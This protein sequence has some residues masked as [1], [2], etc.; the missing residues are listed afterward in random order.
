MKPGPGQPK[1][2]H[3]QELSGRHLP[4]SSN[5]AMRKSFIIHEAGC[6]V[7]ALSEMCMWSGNQNM[8]TLPQQSLIGACEPACSHLHAG[9]MY[10]LSCMAS[11]VH[12]CQLSRLQ[13]SNTGLFNVARASRQRVHL[14]KCW[15]CITAMVFLLLAKQPVRFQ[16]ACQD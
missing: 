10:S 11:T 6:L 16:L 3:K 7:P 1:L 9:E 8:Q 5:F 13:D 14:R 4:M 12:F 2:K 15:I